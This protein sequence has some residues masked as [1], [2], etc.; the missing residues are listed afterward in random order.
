MMYVHYCKA[1]HWVHLLNGHKQKCP[2]CNTTLM[3]LSIPYRDYVAMNITEREIVKTK[4]ANDARNSE[5]S[6]PT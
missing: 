4:C 5:G 3:E 2:R 1:C 6:E